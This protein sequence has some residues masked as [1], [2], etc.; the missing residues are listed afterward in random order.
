MCSCDSSE[1]K[2]R[3]Q[4]CVEKMVE[5][6]GVCSDIFISFALCSTPVRAKESLLV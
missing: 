5:H 2:I 3:I 4:K 6:K 1:H